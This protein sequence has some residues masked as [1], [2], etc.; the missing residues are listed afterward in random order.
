VNSLSKFEPCGK[1][2]HLS[3][4]SAGIQAASLGRTRTS[5][6]NIYEC[7]DC[8]AY[9]GRIIWHVGYGYDAEKLTKKDRRKRKEKKRRRGKK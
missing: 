8:I 4:E 1:V 3:E 6:P 7:D 9:Y 5:R 2:L